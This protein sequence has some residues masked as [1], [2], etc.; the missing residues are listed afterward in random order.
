MQ[1]SPRTGLRIAIFRWLLGA[2]A[3]I[4]TVT[5]L[6]LSAFPDAPH[7][8]A[9]LLT[10]QATAVVAGVTLLFSI[11]PDYQSSWWRFQFPLVLVA[12]CAVLMMLLSSSLSERYPSAHMAN[13]DGERVLE[14]EGII[15]D[16]GIEA[17]INALRNIGCYPSADATCPSTFAVNSPGGSTSSAYS[18]KHLLLNAGFTTI[19][20]DELCASA[21]ASVLFPSFSVRMA[22]ADS[23]IAWHTSRSL[24][25]V[26]L[27]GPRSDMQAH[28]MRAAVDLV[29]AGT[30]PS[31]AYQMTTS[32]D[33]CTMT[34]GQM[35]GIGLPVT[36]IPRTA[37]G[38]QYG[39]RRAKNC[40]SQKGG[41]FH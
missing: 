8:E 36:V 13:H 27:Q 25:G 3:L 26:P 28:D 33:L 5:N 38:P 23:M 17:V 20:V 35:S 19:L 37:E 16:Q 7:R 4:W 14:Y 10:T 34:V 39:L 9:L 29:Q 11:G 22:Y 15:S 32:N 24:L 41:I 30:M 6:V 2:S 1:L 18:L 40:L 31:A 12:L 21:C